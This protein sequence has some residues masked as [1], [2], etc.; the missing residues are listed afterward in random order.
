MPTLYLGARVFRARLRAR[1]REP[2]DRHPSEE[3]EMPH[4]HTAS[5]NVLDPWCAACDAL[6]TQ[7]IIEDDTRKEMSHE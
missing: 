7:A 2:W 6:L 5:P 1:L 3:E 4:R